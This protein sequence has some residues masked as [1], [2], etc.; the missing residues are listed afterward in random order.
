MKI[1]TPTKI[2]HVAWE[3]VL[4]S[5]G[6]AKRGGESAQV[7]IGEPAAWSVEEAMEGEKRIPGQHEP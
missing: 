4:E 2:E 1:I 7:T 3:G 6:E 5:V